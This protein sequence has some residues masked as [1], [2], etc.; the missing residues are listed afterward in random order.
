MSVVTTVIAELYNFP[1]A[2]EALSFVS[3]AEKASLTKV[4]DY[5]FCFINILTFFNLNAYVLA[6]E[7]YFF[8]PTFKALL[9]FIENNQKLEESG[10]K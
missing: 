3:V 2:T 9:N 8:Q 6:S 4:L 7:C 10:L 5:S 1:L